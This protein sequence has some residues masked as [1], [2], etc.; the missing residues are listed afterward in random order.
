M[1]GRREVTGEVDGARAARPLRILLLSQYYAPE[2]GAPQTRLR[3]VAAGLMRRGHAVRVLTG[4]PHYPDGVVR[5][6]YRWWGWSRERI[7]G[8]PIQRMP[9]VPRPHGGLSDRLIDQG[10]FALAAMAALVDVRWS[11]VVVVESPPLF[12]GATAAWHRLVARRPYLFHVADPWPDFPIAMGALARPWQ[13]RAAYALEDLAYRRAALITTV[14]PGLV[15]L[16][17][18][19]P[20]AHGRVRLLPNGVDTGRFDPERSRTD[21]RR[22][23]GWPTDAP[24]LVYAGS[25]GRAQGLGTVL[26]AAAPLAG[27]GLTIRIVGQ[28]YERAAL[29]EEARRRGLGHIHFEAAVAADQIPEVLAAADGILVLLRAGPLYDHSLPTKLLEGLAAGRP[30]LVSAGGEAADLVDGAGAGL[31]APAEDPGALRGIIERF[32][33]LEPAARREMGAAGRRLAET[34][35]DRRAIVD[36]LIGYLGEVVEGPDPRRGQVVRRSR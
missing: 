20:S 3:E 22:R 15:E 18:V 19:K 21:A 31:V 35:Y 14:T 2:V 9:T 25:V 6:G 28:G 13:Q 4:P 16:L 8:V 26:E 29:E 10:S 30:L 12:L 1:S 32:M 5:P 33:A 24:T 7:D 34:T 23:L 27:S 11:D 36:R 17:E